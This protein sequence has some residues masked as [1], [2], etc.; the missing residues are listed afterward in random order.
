MA[1]KKK[2][3]AP[4]E[5]VTPDVV[6]APVETTEAAEVKE[7]KTTSKAK[8][9]GKVT[10]CELLNVREQASIK[11]NRVGVIPKDTEFKVESFEPNSEWVEITTTDGVTGFVM[12]KFVTLK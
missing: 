12:S 1:T 7:T 4:V 5:E 10:G 6:E 2:N 11:S 9:S 3:T 8:K